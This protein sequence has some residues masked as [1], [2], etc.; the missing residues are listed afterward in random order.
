MLLTQY[1]ALKLF[2]FI[3]EEVDITKELDNQRLSAVSS[4]TRPTPQC[5]AGGSSSTSASGTPT[6]P[7]KCQL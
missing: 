1:F 2:L 5:A 4:P 7:G 3:P 6:L